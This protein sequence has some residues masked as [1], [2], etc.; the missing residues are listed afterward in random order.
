MQLIKAGYASEPEDQ[1]PPLEECEE[2][3]PD[4]PEPE[5]S[6]SLDAGFH[7]LQLLQLLR[8]RCDA[9]DGS[10]PGMGDK[11]PPSKSWVCPFA[12]SKRSG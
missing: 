4:E 3:P 6:S 11:S 12:N 7:S 5:E 1:P 2:L 9:S 8:R 10:K